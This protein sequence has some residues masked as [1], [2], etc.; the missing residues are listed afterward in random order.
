MLDESDKEELNKENQGQR[1]KKVN[2]RNISSKFKQTFHLGHSRY[3]F[4]QTLWAFG[5]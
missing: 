3:F 1:K 4:L 2:T 5:H